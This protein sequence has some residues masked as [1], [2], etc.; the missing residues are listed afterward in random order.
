MIRYWGGALVIAAALAGCT[1]DGGPSDLPSVEHTF[2][3]PS[4]I[5]ALFAAVEAGDVEGVRSHLAFRAEPAGWFVGDAV[6]LACAQSAAEELSSQLPATTSVSESTLVKGVQIRSL[7]F[8][9]ASGGTG[10]A[11]SQHGG[12][13][14]FMPDTSTCLETGSPSPSPS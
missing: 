8:Q 2:A 10:L 5:E 11:I 13:W 12:Q 7:W 14:Y 9:Q 4:E 6:P 3:V 1:Q